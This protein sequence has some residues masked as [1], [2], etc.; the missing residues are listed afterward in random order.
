MRVG[1]IA[2]LQRGVWRPLMIHFRKHETE[3]VNGGDE[4]RIMSL[5]RLRVPFG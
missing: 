1:S 4:I 5:D 3:E 2:S